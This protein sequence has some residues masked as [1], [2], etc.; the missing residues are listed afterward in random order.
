MI[1]I[2]NIIKLL[3]KE[4]PIVRCTLDFVN[5]L[6][7][8]ISTQLA[9]Q[10]T[11]ERVNKTTPQLFERYKTAEDFA[12]ANLTDLE[13]LIKP[14]GFFHNK[15]KNIIGCCK[16][17]ISDF[18]G[19]VPDNIDQLITLPGVGRKTANVILA[20]IYNRPAVIVDT[21]T[22][23][24]SIRI[25][26]TDN[27]DPNKI[28]QDLIKILPSDKSAMFCHRLVFH[29]RKICNSRKPLCERCIIKEY[30]KYYVTYHAI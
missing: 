17:L 1:D 18:N 22:K 29:G 25:G 2:Y 9:A 3:E 24:L 15:A 23:R 6:Q 14:T 5:P 11:D 21:H 12:K 10:C 13:Q 30:C 7:L 16:K 20:E 4:Y 27:T 8:L 19:N 28:E 26:L